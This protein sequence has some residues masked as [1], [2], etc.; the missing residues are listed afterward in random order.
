[1][2]KELSQLLKQGVCSES[3]ILAP[4][5]ASVPPDKLLIYILDL[6]A[7]AGHPS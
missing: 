3:A 1:M 6:T 2:T 5:P 7:Q 4:S